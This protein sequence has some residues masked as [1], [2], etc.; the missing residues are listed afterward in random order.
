MLLMYN[1]LSEGSSPSCG[2]D[3]QFL[4]L[5]IDTE[6][7]G[8]MRDAQPSLETLFPHMIELK[9]LLTIHYQV[10][11]LREPPFEVFHVE[12]HPPNSALT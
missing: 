7:A 5:R 6:P 10:S 12:N 3:V 9:A 8:E 1:S 4:Q 11:A 2:R